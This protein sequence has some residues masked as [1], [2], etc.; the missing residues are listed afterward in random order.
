MQLDARRIPSGGADDRSSSA[1]NKP[2]TKYFQVTFAIAESACAQQQGGYGKVIGRYDP[3]KI[4]RVRT[5]FGLKCRQHDVDNTCAE[6]TE[7][8]AKDC[9]N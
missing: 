7:C 8:R 5:K 4:C 1:G 9:G 6:E 2:E 3:L